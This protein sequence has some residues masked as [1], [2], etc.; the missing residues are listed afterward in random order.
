MWPVVV[1]VVLGIVAGAASFYFA[2]WHDDGHGDE[3]ENCW[4]DR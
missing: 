2:T 1:L 4:K 3:H